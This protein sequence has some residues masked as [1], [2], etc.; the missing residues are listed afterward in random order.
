[1]TS[2]DPLRPLATRRSPVAL[3]ADQARRIALGA[4]GFAEPT[5][6]GTVDRRHGRKVLDRVGLIQI[7]SVNVVVRS[8]ELPMFARLG[9]HRRDL[10]PM[11]TKG[12]DLFEYWAHEASHLPVGLQ[13]L[14]RW[15]MD[16]AREG[17]GTWK[18][19]AAIRH[20]EPDLVRSVLDQ[21]RARGPVT[22]S[23]IEGGG[24][25]SEGMWG[26]SPG[27]RALEYLFWSGEITARRGPNFE[28][29]YDLPERMLP[30]SVVEAPTPSPAD[31][32]KELLVIG[33]RSHGVGTARDL[34][35]YF[36]LNIPESRPL[37]DELV[38]EGRLL[39]A[40]VTGWKDKAYLHP[41]ARRP[42]NPRGRALL[43]PFDSLVWERDR[44]ERIWGFR[45]RIEI[46]VPKPKRIHGYYVLPFL[47]DGRLVAR[48]DLKSDRKAG[49]LLVQGAFGE[50]GI[51]EP[52]VAQELLGELRAL[53]AFL[54][55]DGV[56]VK[57]HGDLAPALAAIHP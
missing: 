51:D 11:M 13:P 6:K 10:I 47:L 45:Y 17:R 53:A 27:K 42:N 26:W 22:T 48:V 52:L 40:E 18:G 29:W 9:D 32:K 4:Q 3:T 50:D 25:R 44:T 38:D 46:Y 1:M 35:D 43:S 24:D 19:V 14:L 8:Q 15:R 7:D 36:R 20:E 28:R 49:V 5:P 39:P 23:M 30:A 54:G 16:D 34:A 57:P 2:T 37:L 21:V 56:E 41:D 33:A 31:A 12:G 55:L